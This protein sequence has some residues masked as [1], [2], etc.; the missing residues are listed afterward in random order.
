VRSAALV[1]LLAAA[2]PAEDAY[3]RADRRDFESFYED[4]VRREDPRWKTRAV[5]LKRQFDRGLWQLKTGA[6]IE[7]HGVG[8][9]R[10]DAPGAGDRRRARAE[11]VAT[12]KV[13][14]KACPV[15]LVL[16]CSREIE[17]RIE[18][19]EG[20]RVEKVLLTGP[21]KA[22]V[23]GVD[24]DRVQGIGSLWTFNRRAPAFDRLEA[25]V[26]PRAGGRG[27][28]TFVGGVSPEG[29]PVV[30]GPGSAVWQRQMLLRAM[31]DLHREALRA[32]REAKLRGLRRY[33]FPAVVWSDN[34]RRVFCDCT[35]T[36]PVEDTYE[37]APRAA[38]TAAVDPDT[39]RRY[40]L[41]VRSIRERDGDGK[42]LNEITIPPWVGRNG[43]AVGLAFDARRRRLLVGGIMGGLSAFDLRT[44]DWVP[45]QDDPRMRG[46]QV[47][48]RGH[49]G[50]LTAMA[51]DNTR[52]CAWALYSNHRNVTLVRIG[53][54][55]EP[56]KSRAVRLPVRLQPGGR[57][58][59]VMHVVGDRI[60]LLAVEWS[61]RRRRA[62]RAF[63]IDPASG[64]VEVDVSV[65][66][67]PKLDPPPREDWPLLWEGLDTHDAYPAMRLFA[68][69][70]EPVVAFLRERWREEPKLEEERVRAALAALDS[71]EASVRTHGFALLS[72]GTSRI[73]PRL[74]REIEARESA[75][76]RLALRRLLDFYDARPD[77]RRRLLRIL[78]GIEHPAAAELR[79]RIEAD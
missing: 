72:A 1:F 15:V 22:A 7:V 62:N 32:E 73:V 66:A 61:G 79:K 5:D 69:G 51:Y 26:A 42:D 52:D 37:R 11:S 57:N 2:A 18:A 14:R 27:F 47:V 58:G 23:S 28:D 38:F 53:A 50:W 68:R 29:K 76:S 6:A 10:G 49:R 3:E 8:L 24:A 40:F 48:F 31:R 41:E 25:A 70:G 30:V 39:G 35:V 4:V 71:P 46:G 36:G 16:A 34:G 19:V 17:W 55:G 65:A 56:G 59:T 13:T 74:E 64:R 63:V 9:V 54:L 43:Y 60:A 12:V 45:L 33:V 44:R 21:K 20:A 75:E 77:R 78:D 67:I